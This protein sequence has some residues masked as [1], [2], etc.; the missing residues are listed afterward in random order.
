MRASG[1]TYERQIRLPARFRDGAPSPVRRQALRFVDEGPAPP[2]IPDEFSDEFPGP[3]LTDNRVIQ[4]YETA[5]T[6]Y[7]IFR[8]YPGGVPSWTPDERQGMVDTWEGTGSKQPNESD[9]QNKSPASR[10]PYFDPFPN[11]STFHLTHWFSTG[12]ATKTLAELDRLVEEV[13]LAK[14]FNALDLGKFQT[15]R[16]ANRLNTCQKPSNSPF[17]AEDGWIEG[18]VSIPL[19]ASKF[20]Y[21]SEE[22]APKA[23]ISGIFYKKPLEVMKAALQ[24][25]SAQDFHHTGFREYWQANPEEPPE[26]IYSQVYSADAFLAE[27]AKIRLQNANGPTPDIEPV[28]CSFLLYSDSTHLTNF[29]TSS[30]WPIYGYTRKPAF[31][32]ENKIL[33]YI[34]QITYLAT[35]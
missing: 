6:S 5:K 31:L 15:N 25:R 19:P 28:L 32:L 20:K 23:T 35:K 3:N 26:R 10:R 8:V 22:D 2:P 30:L 9:S 17:L 7:G 29:G 21:K 34:S 12:T 24:E 13:I 33:Y 16:E 1:R 18:T 14:D 4:D 27:E 11:A